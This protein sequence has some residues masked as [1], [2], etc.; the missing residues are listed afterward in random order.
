[1]SRNLAAAAA[2]AEHAR[3]PNP[4]LP[5]GGRGGDAAAAARVRG[6]RSLEAGG[7]ETK[8]EIWTRETIENLQLFAELN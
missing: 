1:M 5:F 2:G 4:P 8:K 3:V 7:L 6:G